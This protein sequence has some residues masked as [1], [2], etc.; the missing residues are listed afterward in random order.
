MC[1]SGPARWRTVASGGM[2]LVLVLAVSACGGGSDTGS[3][4]ADA[5]T[6]GQEVTD[7]TATDT[8][9]DAVVVANESLS[10]VDA[11]VLTV[12][13]VV[14]AQATAT[15]SAVVVRVPVACPGGGSALLSISGGTAGSV[16]NGQLDAGEAYSV[17]FSDCRLATASTTLNGALSFSVDSLSNDEAQLSMGLQSLSAQLA[18][19]TVTLS[20][21]VM[22]QG[23]R[24]AVGSAGGATGGL[25]S[26]L[27]ADQLA[28]STVSGARAGSFEL[29]TLD[30]V[31]EV[32]WANG[33]PTSSSMN[34]RYVF[35][36]TNPRNSF[37]ASV[38]TSGST[39]FGAD[40]L[41]SAGDW[42]ISLTS[43]AMG[44]SVSADTVTLSIDQGN[45]GTVDRS[46][47]FS[48]T[49]LADDAG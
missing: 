42:Q 28:I 22:W 49:Q 14:L 8:A 13:S 19:G 16:S 45:N 3:G 31:R 32:F 12:E 20:G 9:A 23:S 10:A 26:H 33:L 29:R 6:A 44:M 35:A 30:V 47:T 25:T 21:D 17:E 4:E 1:K 18:L 43:W 11:A 40:G 41:P 46:L 2:A 34:G 27:A 15:P 38:T 37:E 5:G 7:A 39:Q 24:S 36:A 48:R